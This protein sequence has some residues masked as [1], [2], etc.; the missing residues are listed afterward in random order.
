MLW[1]EHLEKGLFRAFGKEAVVLWPL[2]VSG[3]RWR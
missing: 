2:G 1:D 3:S